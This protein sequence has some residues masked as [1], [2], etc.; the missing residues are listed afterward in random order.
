VLK[1]EL[2][3]KADYEKKYTQILTKARQLQLEKSK[4][5]KQIQ[6]QKAAAPVTAATNSEPSTANS[7]ESAAKIAD[8]EKTLA[9]VRKELSDKNIELTRLR[10]QFSM[11]Q[12]KTNRLQKELDA[13]KVAAAAASTAK[14]TELSA[15]AP[16][17]KITSP[18]MARNN[19]A[20]ASPAITQ[21][22]ATIDLLKKA[23]TSTG[24]P[25]LSAAGPV[26]ASPL[27]P[28]SATTPQDTTTTA[29]DAEEAIATPIAEEAHVEAEAASTA[30]IATPAAENDVEPIITTPAV[31]D[32]EIT[33]AEE[34]PVETTTTSQETVST[35]AD[36][37]METDHVKQVEDEVAANEEFAVVTE[38]S[39]TE[40]A[41]HAL[42]TE[43]ETPVEVE[44]HELET[45][46]V[47]SPI[48]AS[49]TVVVEE[50]VAVDSPVVFN[51]EET[52]EEAVEAEFGEV[53]TGIKRNR[54]EE[55]DAEISG[56]QSPTK[57]LHTNV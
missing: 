11:S 34:L 19:S 5:M 29:E 23:V 36:L 57:K 32:T 17:F 35:E 10:A 43:E 55:E 52:T 20:P 2:D 6:D 56:T 25:D 27:T 8:L 28:T 45:E 53:V 7:Q 15:A 33:E 18:I 12:G 54:E 37:F 46:K 24:T 1:A 39:A 22:T 48:A 21:K 41:E 16:E 47:E 14:P 38:V 42:T 26:D 13:L 51:E 30:E 9:A 50:D 44:V 4:L 40:D 49:S 31:A 3:K